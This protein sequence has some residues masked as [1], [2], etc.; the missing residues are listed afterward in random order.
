MKISALLLLLMP[1]LFTACMTKKAKGP[2]P[3]LSIMK[4]FYGQAQMRAATGNAS[5]R[6]DLSGLQFEEGRMPGATHFPQGDESSVVV[7]AAHGPQRDA[8][9]V[10]LSPRV[11]G[12]PP[13][14]DSDTPPPDTAPPSQA[15][16]AEALQQGRYGNV[17]LGTLTQA[18]GGQGAPAPSADPGLNAGKTAH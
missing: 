5:R 9:Q 15:E 10:I 18:R 8:V 1:L 14:E 16:L 6:I 7:T 4:R 12:P 17:E 13:P 2:P 11:G 3:P